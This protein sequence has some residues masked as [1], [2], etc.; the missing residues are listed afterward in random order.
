MSSSKRFW[1]TLA[2]EHGF[3]KTHEYA[4][5]D[6]HALSRPEIEEMNGHVIF[7]SH[8][9]FH[10]LLPMCPDEEAATET[11]LSLSEVEG[12]TGSRCEHFS[13]PNGDFGPRS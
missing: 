4:P 7:G 3:V 9:R 13:Y 2:R 5:D 10:A 8:G 6:R 11:K 1:S 12:L